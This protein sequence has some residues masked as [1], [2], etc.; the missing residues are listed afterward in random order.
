MPDWL[1]VLILSVIEGITELLPISSTGH[2]LIAEHWLPRQSDLFNIVIQVGAVIA[3]LPLFPDRLRQFVFGWRE[4]ATWDYAAKIALAFVITGIGGL[5]LDRIG[6]KLPEEL[7]PVAWAVLIGGILFVLI[8]LWLRNRPMQDEVS[9][10][11]ACMVG[12]GQ[13]VA[14][15]FP[16]A[17][18]SGTTILLCLILGL[19]RPAATEFCFLVGIPTMVAAGG[20]QIWKGL[21]QAGPEGTGEAWHLVA[22]GFVVSGIVSFLAVKWLLGYVRTHT[23]MAFGWYR[24]ALAAALFYLL[25]V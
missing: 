4:P 17:S 10:L 16:G 21:G 19:A 3:V 7:A 13:L 23:F 6:Y 8:E 24:I 22:L 2:L 11:M 1:V 14:A 12:A 20:W 9:W 5:V 18:R 15:V 25:A